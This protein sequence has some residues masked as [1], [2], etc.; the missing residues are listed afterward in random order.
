MYLQLA[1]LKN[2]FFVKFIMKLDIACGTDKKP[3]FKGVDLVKLPGV[4]YV[5]DVNKKLKFKDNSVDEIYSKNTLPHLDNAVF[6][7]T[8]FHRI[9]KIGGR[10][11]IIVPHFT[12]TRMHNPFL[13]HEFS[14]HSMDYFDI[15][16]EIG[17]DRSY[18]KNMK[19]SR[20]IIIKREIKIRTNKFLP[21]T[22]L[23]QKWANSSLR[24][25]HLYETYL[26]YRYPALALR[27]VLIK[28]DSK[29][30]SN[31]YVLSSSYKTIKYNTNL[32]SR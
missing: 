17:R 21:W 25:M 12:N 26:S 18:Y 19:D 5:M 13:K 14:L 6:T 28:V 11:E 30:R 15:N 16:T 29:M 1:K 22:Y 32:H 8:E 2:S 9:L 24:N 27:Y 4:D 10:L 3:G 20:F 23:I 7:I 31:P